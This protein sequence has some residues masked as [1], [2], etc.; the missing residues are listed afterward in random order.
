MPRSAA[1]SEATWRRNSGQPIS[2]GAASRSFWNTMAGW[3]AAWAASGAGTPAA[4]S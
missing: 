3:P 4:R 2:I 1:A